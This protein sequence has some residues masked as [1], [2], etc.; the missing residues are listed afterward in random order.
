M[1]PTAAPVSEDNAPSD[2]TDNSDCDTELVDDGEVHGIVCC[3]EEEGE[4]FMRSSHADS[5]AD[6]CVA[7]AHFGLADKNQDPSYV[8]YSK[9]KPATTFNPP[10][11]KKIQEGC[12]QGTWSVA[13]AKCAS[14]G[15]TLCTRAQLTSGCADQTGCWYDQRLVWTSDSN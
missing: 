6:F 14:V 11:A 2:W 5:T 10:G 7:S 1:S 12:M 13:A 4:P 8:I 3:S 15:G 9:K